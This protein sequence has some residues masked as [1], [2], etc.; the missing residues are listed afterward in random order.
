M[1]A[2]H[3]TKGQLIRLAKG[4]KADIAHL[5]REVLVQEDS[6]LRPWRLQSYKLMQ[7]PTD[8]VAWEMISNWAV[9]NCLGEIVRGG[10]TRKKALEL[11]RAGNGGVDQDGG[12]KTKEF[13]RAELYLG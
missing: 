3:L 5:A 4:E 2:L 11:V 6:K 13:Q 9:V 10:I 7:G 1:P 8:P 12:K